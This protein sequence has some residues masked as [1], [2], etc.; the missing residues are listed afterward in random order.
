MPKFK[1]RIV[2]ELYKK[3]VFIADEVLQTIIDLGAAVVPDLELVLTDARDNYEKYKELPGYDTF[4]VQHVLFLL[5]EIGD[6]RALPAVLNFLS[7]PE[8]FLNTW[9]GDAI[10]EDVWTIFVKLGKDCPNLLADCAQNQQVYVYVR[11]AATQALCQIVAHFPDRRATVMGLFAG[12]FKFY[13]QQFFT[14]DRSANTP[15]LLGLTIGDLNRIGGQELKEPIADLFRLNLVDESIISQ[16]MVTFAKVERMPLKSML[17]RYAGWRKYAHFAKQSPYNPNP[18]NP[19]KAIL[20]KH[21]WPKPQKAEPKI[22]RNDLCT[23]GS[24]KKY[25]KCCGKND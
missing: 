8:K 24:G 16:K 12:L 6:S 13:R 2:E 14:G 21:P 17:E 15:V 20:A 1:Y 10:T 7:E 4:F 19:K 22:S 25:K 5:G 11:T 23:C 3:D 9:L 18:A